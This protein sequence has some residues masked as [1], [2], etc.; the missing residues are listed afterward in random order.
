MAYNVS[1]LLAVWEFE[2]LNAW[3]LFYSPY[4]LKPML[5][6]SRAMTVPA[7]EIYSKEKMRGRLKSTQLKNL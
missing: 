2:K 5:C 3:T 7:A 1:G 6:I 4:C